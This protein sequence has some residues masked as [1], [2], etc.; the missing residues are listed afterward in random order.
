MSCADRIEKAK[1]AL[2]FFLQ[3]LPASSYF[4]ICSYGTNYKL[5]FEESQLAINTNIKKALEEI[6]HI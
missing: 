1:K 2:V 4:N 6:K 5:M 3:S